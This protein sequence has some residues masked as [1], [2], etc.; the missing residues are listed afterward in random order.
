MRY[1]ARKLTIIA[2]TAIVAVSSTLSGCVVA[3]PPTAATVTFAPGSTL[4]PGYRGKAYVV[5]D[6]QSRG[7]YEPPQGYAWRYV[8]GQYVLAAV[9]T[10]IIAAA[11][12]GALF[13]HGGHGGPGPGF[14]PR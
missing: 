4:P 9:A 12:L 7:L 11:F 14:G 6:W 10:G 2:T 13:G 5:S 8:D 3:P 1:T